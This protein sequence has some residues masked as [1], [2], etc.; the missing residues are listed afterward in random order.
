M[1]NQL[2]IFIRGNSI[3]AIYTE[4]AVAAYLRKLFPD[5]RIERASHILPVGQ[6]RQMLFRLLRWLFGDTGKWSGW[7]RRWRG[8][9]IVD[10]S[11][12]DAPVFGPFATREEAVQ[13]EL[14]KLEAYLEAGHAGA[15]A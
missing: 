10:F 12:I 7:T 8:P 15:F 9:W 13:F 1:A 5:T 3:R 6:P 4:P 14:A 2:R 11:P